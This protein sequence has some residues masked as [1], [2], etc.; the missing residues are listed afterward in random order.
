MF[1]AKVVK[2]HEVTPKKYTEEPKENHIS[3][4]L[5][6]NEIYIV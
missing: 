4:S 5:K 1:F 3:N 2:E 6:T